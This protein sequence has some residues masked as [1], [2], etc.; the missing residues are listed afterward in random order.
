MALQPRRRGGAKR[1]APFVPNVEARRQMDDNQVDE[2]KEAFRVFDVDGGGTIDSE[3]Y[4]NLMEMLGMTSDP[5]VLTEMFVA[6]DA[7]EDGELQFEEFLILMATLMSNEDNTDDLLDAFDEI[8][9]E[10]TGRISVDVVRELLE[11]ISE[12]C[13]QDEVET[14]CAVCDRDDDGLVSMEDIKRLLKLDTSTGAQAPP[15]KRAPAPA[16][17]PAAMPATPVASEVHEI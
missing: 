15:R 11:G 10:G 7:D 6:M 8:D 3:E 9:V 13:T 5:E 17:A 2:F 16:P 14:L 4:Q 1:R 12:N